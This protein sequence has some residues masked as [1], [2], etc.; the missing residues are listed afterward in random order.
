ML[1]PRKLRGRKPGKDNVARYFAKTRIG[2]HLGGLRMA[3]RIVPQD[4]GSQDLI[5]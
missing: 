4:C 5:R 2:I 3:A 1:G